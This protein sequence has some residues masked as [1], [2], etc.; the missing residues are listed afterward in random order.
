LAVAARA[1]LDRRPNRFLKRVDGKCRDDLF[2][3]RKFHLNSR[4]AD[5]AKISGAVRQFQEKP[6]Y[7]GSRKP[8]AASGK[9]TFSG[10]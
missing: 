2:H 9:S 10:L 5:G 8:R 6:F 3:L 1:I 4:A 7:L